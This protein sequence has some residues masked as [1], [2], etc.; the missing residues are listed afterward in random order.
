ML[1]YAPVIIPGYHPKIELIRPGS[2][3]TFTIKDKKSEKEI[4]KIMKEGRK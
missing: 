3:Q 2:K 1:H 4:I